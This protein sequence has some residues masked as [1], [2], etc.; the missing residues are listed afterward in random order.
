MTPG[1]ESSSWGLPCQQHRSAQPAWAGEE[2][3]G[4]GDRGGGWG[5]WHLLAED[6]PQTVPASCSA[7]WRTYLAPRG[8]SAVITAFYPVISSLFLQSL[9]EIDISDTPASLL[10]LIENFQMLRAH[11]QTE[12]ETQ[13]SPFLRKQEKMV[14]ITAFSTPQ[15]SS[16]AHSLM[17][18]RWDTALTIR[19]L[20]YMYVLTR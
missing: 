14:I 4:E 3:G 6:V 9:E 19:S 13:K 8:S 16:K 12:E 2:W 18:C 5:W 1:Q 20:S 7:S 10:H 11:W 15:I 17:A